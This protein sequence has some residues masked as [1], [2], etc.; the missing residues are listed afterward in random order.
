MAITETDLVRRSRAGDARAADLLDAGPAAIVA[1]QPF[2]APAPRSSAAETS[3]DQGPIG[4]LFRR[5]SGR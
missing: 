4:R 1:D 2:P 5:L 3:R